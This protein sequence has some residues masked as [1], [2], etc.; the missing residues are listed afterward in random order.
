PLTWAS[1][2]R[3]LLR[4][5]VCQP[6]VCSRRFASRRCSRRLQ[7]ASGPSLP[8]T[9]LDCRRLT[10]VPAERLPAEVC[11]TDVC[12]PEPNHKDATPDFLGNEP[13]PAASYAIVVDARQICSVCRGREADAR[14]GSGWGSQAMR[15]VSCM[16][17]TEKASLETDEQPAMSRG[18]FV[19]MFTSYQGLSAIQSSFN[20][21]GGSGSRGL[22]VTYASVVAS[23]LGAGPAGHRAA[24][25][26]AGRWRPAC[27]PTCC[28]W[29]PT[30]TRIG[31][32]II[33]ASV[34]LGVSSA[35]LWA[36]MSVYVVRLAGEY[37]RAGGHDGGGDGTEGRQRSAVS[38]FFGVFFTMFASS[39]IWGNPH[40]LNLALSD[41]QQH[42]PSVWASC[43][44]ATSAAATASAQPATPTGMGGQAASRTAG[45]Q[46]LHHDAAASW[47]AG[48]C[49][50]W[51]LLPAGGRTDSGRERRRVTLAQLAQH[52]SDAAATW[53]TGGSCLLPLPDRQC[54]RGLRGLQPAAHWRGR[55]RDGCA[56]GAGHVLGC[57]SACLV[58]G[59]LASCR[60]PAGSRCAR[61]AWTVAGLLWQVEAEP[62]AYF[63]CY[64]FVGACV[65][66]CGTRSM[67]E[68]NAA[69][70]A[71]RFFSRWCYILG[72][73]LPQLLASTR[74]WRHAGRAGCRMLVAAP[75]W[76]GGAR[77]MRVGG[78]L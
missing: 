60:V 15:E 52:P 35:P 63:Y 58:A 14:F 1:V 39:N 41:W 71:Y 32:T 69:F 4:Q 13:R 73:L 46:V 18:R 6:T 30:C 57:S 8:A 55:S 29:R 70:S 11:Q 75:R 24:G 77:R 25:A 49:Q 68:R 26:E 33:P 23:S 54:R 10:C 5:D 66:R 67:N 3:G 48:C 2:E 78:Q 40:L 65:D 36:A 19:L 51:L 34:L 64:A 12:Q 17:A 62:V 21:V 22:A 31:A 43:R 38:V 9:K 61:S 28:T 59:R 50:S 74:S 7:R 76:T 37:A 27:A 47:A 20:L 72:F 44:S 45:V 16:E 42:P 56:T 53:R